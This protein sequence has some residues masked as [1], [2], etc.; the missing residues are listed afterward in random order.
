MSREQHPSTPLFTQLDV[1]PL[2]STVS[3]NNPI[4]QTLQE[5][6]DLMRDL[7]SAQDRTNEL[8]EDLVSS[9][10]LAQKQRNSDL[11]QWKKANPALARSCREAAEGLSQVQAR[12]LNKMT[13]EINLTVEDLM[14]GEFV[15][16]E[17]VDRFGPRLAHLNGMI[18]VLAQLSSLPNPTD[19]LG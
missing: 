2:S 14:D 17:F 19:S 3:T 18:Q 6:S 8:L 15:L 13:E 4:Q 16:T 11:N 5:Q 10:S 1:A 9:L 7:L 12:F